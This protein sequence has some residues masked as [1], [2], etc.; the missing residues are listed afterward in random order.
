MWAEGTGLCDAVKL[1]LRAMAFCEFLAG[2][3]KP[4]PRCAGLRLE[5][6]TEGKGK[7]QD[8]GELEVHG[9]KD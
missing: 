6:G 9:S 5:L 7:N 2:G 1:R 8:E 4:S 3:T